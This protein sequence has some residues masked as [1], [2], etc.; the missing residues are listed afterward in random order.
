[1]RRSSQGTRAISRSWNST[2]YVPASAV[3]WP[4]AIATPPG[5]LIA[6]WSPWRNHSPRVTAPLT[7]TT[8]RTT[9]ARSAVCVRLVDLGTW[10]IAGLRAPTAVVTLASSSMRP[11]FETPLTSADPRVLA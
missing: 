9:N 6:C 3:S 5:P 11:G 1:M 4:A 8:A 2:A 7:A 10:E